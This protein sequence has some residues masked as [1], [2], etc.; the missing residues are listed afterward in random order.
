ML[1]DFNNIQLR[2]FNLSYQLLILLSDFTALQLEHDL[3]SS[4]LAFSHHK[5]MKFQPRMSFT[6]DKIEVLNL[7]NNYEN[8]LF[9]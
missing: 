4:Y 8:C 6:N 9:N 7:L 2:G 1:V 3:A 5:Q